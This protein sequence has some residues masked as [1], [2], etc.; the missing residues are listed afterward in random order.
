MFL[1]CNVS[2]EV[3]IP[4]DEDTEFSKVAHEFVRITVPDIPDK[5]RRDVIGR[6]A[7]AFIQQATKF[8]TCLP[9]SGL[10]CPPRHVLDKILRVRL[11]IKTGNVTNRFAL[12]IHTKGPELH[13]WAFQDRMVFGEEVSH[14]VLLISE[15]SWVGGAIDSP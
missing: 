7:D 13:K 12:F 11:D 15:P 6:I 8:L 5:I 3:R 1:L 2:G 10:T 9:A 14:D 4:G